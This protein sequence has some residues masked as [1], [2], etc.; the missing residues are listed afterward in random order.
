MEPQQEQALT[1]LQVA[2]RTKS[3]KLGYS[4]NHSLEMAQIRIHCQIQSADSARQRKADSIFHKPSNREP[5]KSLKKHYH[6]NEL[7]RFKAATVIIDKVKELPEG[8]L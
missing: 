6:E 1:L 7:L 5:L 3:V 8:L 2:A 4:P